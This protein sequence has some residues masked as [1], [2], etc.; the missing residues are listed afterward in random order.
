MIRIS[1]RTHAIMDLALGAAFIAAP[2]ILDALG[3][4]SNK[5]RK[6]KSNGRKNSNNNNGSGIEKTLLPSMGV[7]ILAQG[8]M[9]NHELG[10][11]K[12]L[13]MTQHL[14]MD[15]GLGAFMVAAPWLMDMEDE[16]CVPLMVAGASQIALALLTETEPGYQQIDGILDD[17]ETFVEEISHIL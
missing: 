12:A 2:F 1:T 16:L 4:N 9:T 10:A 11:V 15:I 5:G 3:N 6:G 17:P 7:G 13:S 14:T 8:I